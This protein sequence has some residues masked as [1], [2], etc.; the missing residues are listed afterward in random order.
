LNNNSG[1]VAQIVCPGKTRKEYQSSSFFLLFR[2]TESEMKEAASCG[3]YQHGKCSGVRSRTEHAAKLQGGPGA[4][5]REGADAGHGAAVPEE[6]VTHSAPVAT[7]RCR[8]QH[9]HLQHMPC[10]PVK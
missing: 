4:Q 10:R 8:G 3:V 2:V 7:E 5:D 1:T 9:H 6:Q